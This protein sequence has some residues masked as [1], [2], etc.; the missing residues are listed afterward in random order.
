MLKAASGG[1]VALVVLS[2]CKADSTVTPSS[3]G[4]PIENPT[5]LLNLGDLITLNVNG[6][7]ACSNAV[8]HAARV[9]A[10]G[11]K[12]I[13]LA[14]TLNPRNGFTTADYQR[15][16]ARFDTL[17]YPLDVEHF[18]EP[19]DIDK[20]QRIA[21]V[22]TR[23]VNELTPFRSNSY[24]GG[25]AFSRDLF[26]H[27]QTAR[28]SACAG[29]NQG[30]Y[31]Y[32]LTPD[33][34]GSINGNVRSAT[35][36]DSVTTA[37]LAHELEHII[38]SSRH[39][40]V[41]D[42]VAF[43]EKWLDEGL[44]HIA[45]ELLFYRESGLAPRRNL[46]YAATRTPATVRFAYAADMSGNA[47]RYGQ[48]LNAPAKNSPYALDDSLPTRGATWSFLRYAADRLVA[49]D[50]FA[51]GNGQTVS[52]SGDIPLAP[53]A[54]SGEYSITVVNTSLVG[55]STASFGLRVGAASGTMLAPVTAT[56]NR[57]PIADF[58]VAGPQRDAGFESRL[59][60][61][62]R[63]ALTPLMGDARRWYG[64]QRLRVPEARMSVS[65]LSTSSMLDFDGGIW[66]RLV[67]SSTVGMTNLRAVFGSD[68]AGLVRDWSVSLAV[69]DVAS[70]NTQYQQRSWNFRSIYPG[71]SGGLSP[72]PL[73]IITLGSGANVTSTVSGGGSSF[74]RITIPANGGATISLTSPTGSPNTNIQ[75]VIVRTK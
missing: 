24:V 27:K 33:P 65:G 6:D 51:A 8:Y 2:A 70:P 45:E 32:A 17:V 31:F 52:G 42:A 71:Q 38:N 66:S 3:G 25:F 18:G 28:A 16:A 5:G 40:Y 73:Q 50:G 53:G 7:S 19:T 72:Y 64:A 61:R 59:R 21:I 12:S 69:D 43:E 54:T 62:E 20:N 67:N 35:F 10:V 11:T 46:D 1:I 41:T 30:E 13:I 48:F 63:A 74:Y 15:F 22:F 56:A 49:N 14:D 75:L 39:L 55:G 23:A 4:D 60:D 58:E 34:T 44:A 36:V 29:S 9:V 26:P 37:V 68:I 47:Q 57:V